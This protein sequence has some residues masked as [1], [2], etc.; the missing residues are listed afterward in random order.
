MRFICKKA[1]KRK[2]ERERIICFLE[3]S[4]IFYRT[5][6]TMASKKDTR[7]NVRLDRAEAENEK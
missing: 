2:R 5:V 1:K 4:N 7:G 6:N 3:K